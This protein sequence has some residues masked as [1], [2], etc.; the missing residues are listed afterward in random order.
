MHAGA[1]EATQRAEQRPDDRSRERLWTVNWESAQLDVGADGAIG[2][3]MEG[4]RGVLYQDDK[5]TS[6]FTAKAADA[7]RETGVL[8]LSGDV[9]VVSPKEP[10]SPDFFISDKRRAISDTPIAGARLECEALEWRSDANVIAAKGH[11]RV[12]TED[13]IAGPEDELWT[14]SKLTRVGTPDRF[15][16]K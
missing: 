9:R 3:H 1:G 12:V 8:K 6:Y 11:V 7:D 2:G 15:G 16:E 4:V 5:P 13:W 14:N 10:E